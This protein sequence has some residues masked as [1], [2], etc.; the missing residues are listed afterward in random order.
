MSLTSDR[1]IC[2]AVLFGVTLI[3]GTLPVYLF[4][5]WT[6]RRQL[7]TVVITTS[8]HKNTIL[9][10]NFYVQVLTQIGGGI[11]FFTVFVHMLPEIRHD[12]E[13]YVMSNSSVF[14]P[15]VSK[16]EDLPLPYLELAICGGFFFMHLAE[17]AMHTIL[18][19]HDSGEPRE[20]VYD[21]DKKSEKSEITL[22]SEASGQHSAKEEQPVLIAIRCHKCESKCSL[23]R[24]SWWSALQTF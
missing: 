10:A 16:V 24:S 11:L 2:S 6:R 7:R 17:V 22:T 18:E 23:P 21:F 14:E 8:E 15:H 3:M 4:Q 9:S 12:F 13:E 19:C 5:K 20:E 1:L